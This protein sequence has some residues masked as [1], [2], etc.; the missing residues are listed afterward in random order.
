MQHVSIQH[1]SEGPAGG[2]AVVSGIDSPSVVVVSWPPA[3][4]P[5]AKKPWIYMLSSK[6]AFR[7]DVI[8]KRTS[9]RTGSRFARARYIAAV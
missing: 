4:N 2:Q 7:H 3:A 1:K 8:D 9:K 6:S 5:F